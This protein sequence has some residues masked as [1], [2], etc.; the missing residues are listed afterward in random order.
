MKKSLITIAGFDP[1]GGAGALLDLRAFAAHGFH[2]AAVLTAVTVQN[3]ARVAGVTALPPRLVRGQFAALARDIH[4]AGIKVGMLGTRD[5]LAEVA[6]ILGSARGIPKVV[7]PIFRSSSGADLLAP[8]AV[9]DF[10]AAL[11]GRASLLTPNLEE[12]GRLTGRRK[13][14]EDVAVMKRAAEEIF[15]HGR[16]PCLVK[17]GHLEGDPVDVLYDGSRFALLG[18]RRV[19]KEAH[20]TGCLLSAAILAGLARGKS[21]VLACEAGAAFVEAALREAARVGKGRPVFL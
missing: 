4:C 9:P 12:A 19:R 11:R 1:S 14:I 18:R 10:L 20:G 6:R 15:E 13:R 8:A 2:G 17:G 16:I 7:D 3:T 21:L 5:N